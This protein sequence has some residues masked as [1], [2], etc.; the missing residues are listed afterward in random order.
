MSVTVE[1][2]RTPDAKEAIS[3]ASP[4]AEASCARALALRDAAR[5]MVDF[6]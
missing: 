6:R 3:E 2:E 5:R 4:E 1:N